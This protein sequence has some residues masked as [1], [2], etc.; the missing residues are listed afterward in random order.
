MRRGLKFGIELFVDEEGAYTTLASAVSMLVVLAL[1]FSA[2]TATWS[3]ARSGDVQVAADTSALAG[4]NVVSSYHTAATVVDAAV[5]SMGLAGLAVA[6]TGLVGLLI[7]GANAVAAET[8]QA[9]IRIIEMRNSFAT[10]ASRGLERVEGALPYLV[11]A[12]GARVCAAQSGEAA[13]YTG[14]ALAVP[15]ASAS[16]FPALEGEGVSTEELEDTA[17]RLDEAADEL[18]EAARATARAQEAAWLADC[19]SAGR[20]MQERAGRLAGL[21]ASE[22]PDY[23]SSL[24]WRP[25]VGLER[26]RS[27]YRARLTQEA[28]EGSSVEERADSAARRFFFEYA[29]EQLERA[30]IT[31]TDDAV[32]STVPLLPRNTAEVRAT[33]LYTDAVWP[34]TVEA[35]GTTLHFSTSCPGATGAAGPALALS[36]IDTGAARECPV[37]RFSVGDVGKT[38]AASTSIDN[39]FEHHLRAFTQA[40]DDYVACRNRELALER[41]ARAEADASSDAFAEALS[42]LAGRRPKIAPPG[43]YGCVGVATSSDVSSTT[44]FDG[45]HAGTAEVGRTVAISAAALAPDAA[46]SENNVLSQFFVGLSERAGGG[47]VAGL[48]DDVMG[49]WGTILVSYGDIADGLAGVM[50]NLVGGLSSWGMGP[51]ATWLGDKLDAVVRGVG[52]EPVDLGT[53]KPVLT[54]SHDVLARSDVADA[55]RIQEGL[56]SLAPATTDPAAVAQA[57]GY[58]V[59]ERVSATEFTLA[60]I[61]LPG[62]GTLP[63]TIRLGDVLQVAGGGG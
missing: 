45:G 47:G 55:A 21:A 14:A 13:S 40:L 22:N 1:L 11:A 63:L 33:T 60:E 46:T 4:A 62:G 48:V 9:G 51:L 27:Y 54:D 19:G 6:G 12:N 61:P 39:G 37:C 10:S 17:G 29:L 16:E 56:R 26:A 3:L 38:P 15:R 44:A 23:A 52:L 57:V 49:L 59:G 41:A 7:P 50:D 8:V 42:V 35:E 36:A 30:R 18:E 20:N 5:L 2:A 53:R 34:S 31:E 43:R 24:T 32:V 25:I 28:P 58:E